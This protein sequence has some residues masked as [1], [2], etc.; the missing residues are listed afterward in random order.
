M[1]HGIFRIPIPSN[2]P[3]LTYAPG[4]PERNDL[5]AALKKFKGE[6]ADLPMFIWR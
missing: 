1:N 3:N 2:E 5:K 6:Q 4:T